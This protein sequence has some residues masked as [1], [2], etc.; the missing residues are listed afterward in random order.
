MKEHSAELFAHRGRQ[1][2]FLPR[3]RGYN[4]G[5]GMTIRKMGQSL[6]LTPRKRAPIKRLL[7]TIGK[8]EGFPERQQPGF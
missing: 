1:A 3:I 5:D 7:G 8:F 6:V 4:L 2:V